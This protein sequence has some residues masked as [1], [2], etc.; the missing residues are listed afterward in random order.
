MA[1]GEKGKGLK[2][3]F[4]SLLF[5]NVRQ[6]IRQAI[7]AFE[8]SSKDMPL[9]SAARSYNFFHEIIGNASISQVMNYEISSFIE[10]TLLLGFSVRRATTQYYIIMLLDD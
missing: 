10:L 5:I 1:R 3:I 6:G 9:I 8:V 2:L 4:P 7:Q